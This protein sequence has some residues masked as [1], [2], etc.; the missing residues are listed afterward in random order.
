MRNA[1]STVGSKEF[2]SYAALRRSRAELARR[3][4]TEQAR[5]EEKGRMERGRTLK[6]HVREARTWDA[7]ATQRESGVLLEREQVEQLRSVY[8][9]RGSRYMSVAQRR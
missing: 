5:V 9:A 8:S 7:F 6:E 3:V 4:T 1:L 2:S